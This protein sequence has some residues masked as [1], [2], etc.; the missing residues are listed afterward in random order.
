[1]T[2]TEIQVLVQACKMA[3]IDATKIKP[4]NPFSKSGR[5]AE[6]L[7][8]AVAEI[9][10]QQAAKWRVDAGG[11]LSLATIAEQQSGLPLSEAARRDLFL[12]DPGFVS[13]ARKQQQQSEEQLL[14]Q[15]E[16]SAADTRLRNTARQYG[17]DVEYAKR[18]LKAEDERDAQLQQQRIESEKQAAAMQ[19]RIAQRQAQQRV[20]GGAF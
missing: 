13:E 3:G 16:K 6:F 15:M 10:P 14:A 18:K 7:Q 1:M 4:E 9:D 8:A 2:K 17:G 11:G 5:T 12:H 19:Q 20:P